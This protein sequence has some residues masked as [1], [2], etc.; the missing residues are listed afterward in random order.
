MYKECGCKVKNWTSADRP[1]LLG[2]KE[3]N[4][5]LLEVTTE[6]THR[7]RQRLQSGTGCDPGPRCPGEKRDAES[8]WTVSIQTGLE[9]QP[10]RAPWG[11]HIASQTKAIGWEKTQSHSHSQ[12]VTS[13]SLSPGWVTSPV[14]RP[15]GHELSRTTRCT[16]HITS[17]RTKV[18]NGLQIYYLSHVCR[19]TCTYTHTSAEGVELT[20]V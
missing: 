4:T 19:C 11:L 20:P 17:S 9:P 7:R 6:R 3:K 12:A 13:V 16:V 2:S 5:F 14:S 15:W 18:K 1:R 10:H 8:L